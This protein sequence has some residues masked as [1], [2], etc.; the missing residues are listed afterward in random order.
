MTNIEIDASY[1]R[2][3][4]ESIS[5]S[6]HPRNDKPASSPAGSIERLGNCWNIELYRYADKIV[7]SWHEIHNIV[8]KKSENMNVDKYKIEMLIDGV[9]SIINDKDFKFFYNVADKSD[10]E[11]L[12]MIFD[13]MPYFA[14]LIYGRGDKRYDDFVKDIE[15]LSK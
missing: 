11:R 15:A 12:D 4:S 10:K 3:R 7:E 1:K 13:A 2:G 8:S 6:M 14:S 9:R 5:D